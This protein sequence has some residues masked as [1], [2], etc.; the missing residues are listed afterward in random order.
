MAGLTEMRLPTFYLC[1]GGG[2]WPWMQGP[3]REMLRGLEEGLHAIVRG[4]PARP[5][6]VLVVSSHWE[7]DVFT[8][9]AA[10]APGMVYDYQGFPAEMYAIRYPAPGHPAL[11]SRVQELLHAQGCRARL[12]PDQ[13]FDHSTYSLLK[14]M[15]PQAELPVL[16]MSLQRGLDPA[17]HLQAGAALATLRDEGVLIIGSGMSCHDRGPGLEQASQGFDDWLQSTLAGRDPEARRDALRHWER[18]PFARLVHS[19]EDHL[20][21]LMVAVGAA[22]GDAGT[23]VYRDRLMGRLAVSS[24]AFGL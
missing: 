19:R 24:H 14:P 9:T 17:A 16:Q 8:L 15:F 22:E 21:P 6:A 18:A 10:D 13:G 2:P 20:L 23:C 1:H 11:A 3:L 7:E 12:S 5:R 4:L